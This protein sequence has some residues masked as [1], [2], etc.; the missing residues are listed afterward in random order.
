MPEQVSNNGWVLTTATPTQPRLALAPMEGVSD[1]VARHLLSSLGGMDLCVT[2]F[3]RVTHQPLSSKR[4]LQACPELQKSGRTDSGTPV[5]VQLLGS[6]CD[7]MAE[8]AVRAINLG[9]PGIDLNFGCPARRVNGNDGGAAILRTPYRIEAVVQAVRNVVPRD[10]PVSAKIRLGWDNPSEVLDI[11]GAAESG[12]AA[13]ITIHG[14]TKTQLYRPSADWR[15][16]GMAQ[17]SVRVPVIANGD[18]FSPEDIHRCHE[19][20]GC[21]AFMLGR[22]AFMTPNLFRWIRGMDTTPWSPFRSSEL[23]RQFAVE[24]RLRR[25]LRTPDRAILARLKQW[26]RYLSEKN[27]V[28]QNCF[29]EL[30]RQQTLENALQTLDNFFPPTRRDAQQSAPDGRTQTPA[31]LL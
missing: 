26:T 18:L 5:L 30:K 16:I 11:V 7:A 1:P 13:F 29:N 3:V 14:R 9:A 24:M 17:N 22:G 10:R 27:E 25:K 20:S 6:D 8:T 12:G 28:M 21:S 31:V 2:E 19:Q 4:L 23:L 15:S